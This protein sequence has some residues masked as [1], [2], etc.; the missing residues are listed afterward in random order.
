M[1]TFLLQP[2]INLPVLNACK[3]NYIVGWEV[4]STC[5]KAVKQD[6]KDGRLGV[7]TNGEE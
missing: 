2:Y 3:T 1:L 4:A 7:V 6:G 5:C